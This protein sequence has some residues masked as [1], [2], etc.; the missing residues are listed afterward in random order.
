MTVNSELVH[1]HTIKFRH[2]R[3]CMPIAHRYLCRLGSRKIALTRGDAQQVSQMST[4]RRLG[5][6]KLN[7]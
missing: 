3:V 6:L 2:L 7:F 1:V 4:V 5:I